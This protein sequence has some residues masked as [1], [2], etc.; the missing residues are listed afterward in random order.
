M[1]FFPSS[2]VSSLDF[3]INYGGTGASFDGFLSLRSAIK[4]LLISF[5]FFLPRE[6]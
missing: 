4:I 5:A 1:Q 3:T 6:T 2:R